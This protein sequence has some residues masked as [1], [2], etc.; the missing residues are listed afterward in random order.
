M[1]K[2]RYVVWDWNGTLLDDL[3]LAID[4]MGELLG[5]YGLPELDLPR[6]LEIFEF[7]AQNYYQSLGFNTTHPGFEILAT[8]FMQRYERRVLECA[9]HDGARAKLEGFAKRGVV[10]IILTAGEERSVAKQVV[11]FGLQDF[12]SEVVGNSDHFARPKDAIGSNW[13]RKRRFEPRSMVYVGDTTHDFDVATT[14]EVRCL[15]VSHG[16]NSLRRLLSCDCTVV[17]SLAELPI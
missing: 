13:L 8:Q 3:K 6:Y 2:L 5:S 9:L 7:P 15:L 14:M 16:H 1:S 17:S 11:H 10:N 12:V 4:V